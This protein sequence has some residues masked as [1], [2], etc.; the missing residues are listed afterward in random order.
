MKRISVCLLLFAAITLLGFVNDVRAAS[1]FGKVIEVNDGDAITVFNLNRQVRV[2]LMGIDAPETGQPFADVAKQHLRDLV[3]DKLVT[4]D[5]SG[6][7]AQGMIVGKVTVEG[8]DVCA[9]MVRDGAAWFDINNNSRLTE[10]DREIYSQSEAAARAEKRG[11]WQGESIAPWTWAKLQAESRLPVASSNRTNKPNRSPS[12]SGE[13]T[14]ISLLRSAS[15]ASTTA[16][17]DMSWAKPGPREWRRFQ[18]AGGKFSVIVPSEGRNGVETILFRDKPID[19][20]SYASADGE[21]VYAIVWATGPFLGETDETAMTFA[22]AGLIN[23]VT[24]GYEASGGKFDCPVKAF[25]EVGT[26]GFAGR[27]YDLGRCTLPGVARV[28]TRVEDHERRLII[29]VT[30]SV[31]KDATASKRFLQSFSL[32][33]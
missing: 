23:G 15:S 10:M 21:S 11:L 28:Y 6:L 27:E 12:S 20:H 7:G 22:L 33:Q 3:L 18:P 1:L 5:Y 30:F 9:Q 14:T 32:E 13:L 4:V 17:G 25:A 8:V 2:K 16:R 26:N 24:K 29:G 19:F 31:Q